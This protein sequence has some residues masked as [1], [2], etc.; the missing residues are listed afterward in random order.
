MRS[1]R[2]PSFTKILDPTSSSAST[3]P[4]LV[5]A[6]AT[7]ERSSFS[8]S[9]AFNFLVKRRMLSA[10][11][12]FL[13]RMRSAISRTFCGEAFR[14]LRVAV[15]SISSPLC[16]RRRCCRRRWR[17]RR[18]PRSGR[19]DHLLHFLSAVTLEG[20]S[21]SELA[22]PVPDHVLGDVHRH[23]FAAVVHSQ[24]GTDH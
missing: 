13:P 9:L 16:L 12:T 24:G 6:L 10:S 15:A 21:E 23:E 8:R 1:R 4:S 18:P 20:A 17:S 14:Y 7:A 5:S 11:S 3:P 19:P 2:G 22:E